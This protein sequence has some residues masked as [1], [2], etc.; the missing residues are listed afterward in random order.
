MA[1][2]RPRVERMYVEIL[3]GISQ[4]KSLLKPLSAKEVAQWANLEKEI[5]AIRDN[6][7]GFIIPSEL[8]TVN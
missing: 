5:K 2:D 7:G 8:P 3:L 4:N 6:G 1:L